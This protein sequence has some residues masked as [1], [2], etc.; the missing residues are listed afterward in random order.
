MAY[1]W[2]SYSHV[3]STAALAQTKE[4]LLLE[5]RYVANPT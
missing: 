1:G 3:A 2:I 5:R 4:H